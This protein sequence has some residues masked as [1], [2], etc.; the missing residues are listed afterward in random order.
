MSIVGMRGFDAEADNLGD[1]MYIDTWGRYGGVA[2]RRFQY[3]IDQYHIAAQS[4]TV[5]GTYTIISFA[6]RPGLSGDYARAGLH[7]AGYRPS[8]GNPRMVLTPDGS[9]GLQVWYNTTPRTVASPDATIASVFSDPDVYYYI[10]YKVTFGASGSWELKVDGT[11]V[12]SASSIDADVTGGQREVQLFG[13]DWWGFV[14]TPSTLIDMY[15]DDYIIID[16]TGTRNTDYLGDKRIYLLPAAGGA[17]AGGPGWAKFPLGGSFEDAVNQIPHDSGTSYMYHDPVTE[18]RLFF[19]NDGLVGFGP[20]DTIPSARL[21]YY[22]Q[23]VDNG[24]PWVEIDGLI[25]NLASDEFLLGATF[26]TETVGWYEYSAIVGGDLFDI[27]FSELTVSDIETWLFGPQLVSSSADGFRVTGIYFEIIE[28]S[29]G[30]VT[31]GMRSW[32][33][34]IG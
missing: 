1:I 24:G 12:G 3:T 20:S 2:M 25:V 29:L 31:G 14:T 11:V 34:I 23:R 17:T 32:A 19:G 18:N 27:G 22:C 30:V 5:G 8:T 16:S 28:P 15:I 21:L 6:F 13:N 9:G 7:I 33:T 10:E 26:L 4:F